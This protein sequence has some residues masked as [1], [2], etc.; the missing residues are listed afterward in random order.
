MTSRKRKAVK[1][2]LL[3]LGTGVLPFAVEQGLQGSPYAA[4]AAGVIGAGCIGTYVFV[5]DVDKVPISVE[6]LEKIPQALGEQID[7]RERS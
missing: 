1:T 6:D 5:D 4:G 7:K 3:T 2:S